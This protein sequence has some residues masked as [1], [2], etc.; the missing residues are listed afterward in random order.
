[1][2]YGTSHGAL[3]FIKDALIDDAFN[4][5]PVG[6]TG[7]R[8]SGQYVSAYVET[9]DTEAD[10]YG[11][12]VVTDTIIVELRYGVAR[13]QNRRRR[14]IPRDN[15]ASGQFVQED[16]LE[17]VALLRH[18]LVAQSNADYQVGYSFVDNYSTQDTVMTVRILLEVEHEEQV[19]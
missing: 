3:S 6:N 9:T 17:E 16:A 13:T 2:A 7:R 5:L 4:L 11:D 18:H 10:T 15:T 1:M 12:I 19:T 8:L 14:D